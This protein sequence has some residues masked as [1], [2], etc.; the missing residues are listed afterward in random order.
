MSSIGYDFLTF[1]RPLF[2]LNQN[3]RDALHDPGLYLFRTGIEIK[4]EEYAKIYAIIDHFFQ[5]ELRPFSQIRKDVYAYAFGHRKLLE[6][7][8]EKIETAIQS[9]MKRVSL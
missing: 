9:Y 1:D 6:E 3:T 8:K 2:F 5:F 4:R 7:I